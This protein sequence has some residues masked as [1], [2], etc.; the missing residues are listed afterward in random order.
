MNFKN[1]TIKAQE[2]IQKA[3]EIT[4]GNQQQAVE[5]AH[6]MKALLAV[7]E[8]IVSHLLKKLDVNLSYL[9]GEIDKLVESYPKVSGSQVYLSSSSTS[10]LQKAEGYLKEFNDFY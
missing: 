1:Y 3:S 2:A 7:D 10:V 5:A 4:L 6:I 9:S 8:N